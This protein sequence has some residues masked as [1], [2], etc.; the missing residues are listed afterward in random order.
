MLPV[1]GMSVDKAIDVLESGEHN[2]TVKIAGFLGQRTLKDIAYTI[3]KI[4]PR[5]AARDSAELLIANILIKQDLVALDL[6]G[7]VG[8]TEI[9][10]EAFKRCISLKSIRIPDGVTSIGNQAFSD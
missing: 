8:V 10:S 3:T 9:E 1:D 2:G 5:L 6:S 7:L 4:D